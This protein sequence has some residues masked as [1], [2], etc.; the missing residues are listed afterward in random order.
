MRLYDK[1]IGMALTGS[2]CMYEKIYTEM[3]HLVEEPYNQFLLLSM[4]YQLRSHP[5]LVFPKRYL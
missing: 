2:F 4:Q 3:K 5:S 1:R